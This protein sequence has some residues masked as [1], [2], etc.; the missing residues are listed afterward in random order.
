MAGFQSIVGLAIREKRTCKS[1]QELI[2]HSIKIS[3]FHQLGYG[4]FGFCVVQP[5][6]RHPSR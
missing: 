5:I 1:P 3:G 4:E 2:L 6:D